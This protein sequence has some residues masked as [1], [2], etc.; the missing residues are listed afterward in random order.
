MSGGLQWKQRKPQGY[1]TGVT[2]T[3]IGWSSLVDLHHETHIQTSWARFI[4][5]SAPF[6]PK[7]MLYLSTDEEL[8][9]N[10]NK[11]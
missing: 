11:G 7:H 3:G 6:F 1:K 8:P 4:K 9:N 10:V 2:D 5:V